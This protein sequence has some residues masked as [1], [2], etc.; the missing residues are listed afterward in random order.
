MENRRIVYFDGFCN[1]C[2]GIVHWLIRIDKNKLLFFAYLD[3]DSGKNLLLQLPESTTKNTI[4]FHYNNELFIRSDAVLQILKV[5]GR[6][7]SIMYLFSFLHGS[8]RNW[9]YDIIAKNRY[10]WFGKKKECMVPER[11]ILNRFH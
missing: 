6:P 5:L 3:S 1:L 2:S 8:I 4:L 7:W 10:N 11:E 9:V